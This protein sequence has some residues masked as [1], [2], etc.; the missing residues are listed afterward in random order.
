[1]AAVDVLIP[2]CER[3][4]ALAVTLT[5]LAAQTFSDFRVVISDQSE[6]AVVDES[7]EVTAVRRVL[8]EQGHEVSTQ[9]HVPR[10]GMAEQRWFLLQ[11]AISPHVLFIDDDLILDPGVL[12]RLVR[13]LDEQRC[14]FVGMAPIGLSYR[15]DVRPH[16]QGIERFES[17]VEPECVRPGAQQW[18]RYRLHSAANPLHVQKSL[19][20]GREDRYVYRVAWVGGCVL[21]DREKLCSAGGFDFWPLLPTQHCGEDVLAQLLVAKRFGGCGLL[22]SGVF[23]MELATTLPDR[24]VNAPVALE[25][26]LDS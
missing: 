19:G 16:E 3:P 17:C 12:E 26:L 23:H 9:R 2:T 25:W 15:N 11:Q 24:S 22:P 4:A 7:R 20:L 1:M 6:T 21:Y 14:G 10:A 18:Q 8:E 5:S 13:T